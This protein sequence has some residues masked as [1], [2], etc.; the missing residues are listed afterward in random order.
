MENFDRLERILKQYSYQELNQEDLEFVKTQIISEGEYEAL[1]Q[2][3]RQLSV[4]GEVPGERKATSDT[5]RRL[6]THIRV[7]KEQSTVP[8][9][10][11]PIPAYGVAMLA[12]ALG[13]L[14]WWAGASFGAQVQYVD[15]IRVRVDTLR[16]VARPDTVVRERIVYVQASAVAPASLPQIATPPV[17]S[18][19]ISM[20]EKEELERL[21]VSGLN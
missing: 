5:W 16:M 11:K 8:W 9:F 17:A 12:I 3:N 1:R 7:S 18:K 20:K 6:R 21:L 10:R 19:G 14:C 15:R 4:A 2:I 13:V